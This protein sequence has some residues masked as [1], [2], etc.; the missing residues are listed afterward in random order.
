MELYVSE[1]ILQGEEVPFYLLWSRAEVAKVG[2]RFE[3]FESISFLYNVQ[4]PERAIAKGWVLKED[5]KANGY[6]GGVLRTKVVDEPFHAARLD[7]TLV[8]ENGE[9]RVLSEKRTLN[10][11]RVRIVEFPDTIEVP[12]ATEAPR[13][14]VELEGSVT[15][16]MR[17]EEVEGSKLELALPQEIQTAMERFDIAFAEGLEKLKTEFPKYAKLIDDLINIPKG[18]SLRQYFDRAV[19]GIE[20]AR[21]DEDFME[22][23]AMAFLGALVGQASV[24][25]TFFLPLVEYLEANAANKAFFRSP[26]LCAKVPAG[27]GD[28]AVQL[29]TRD[30]L[31]N[32]CGPPLA[33]KM[34]FRSGQEALVPIKDIIQVRRL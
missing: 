15:V 29:E 2:L 4:D 12:L 33:I 10:T 16:F 21:H 19:T 6:L 26:F 23:M 17:V 1:D 25:D 32:L 11:T 8:L 5:L 34:S 14:Q 31:D 30:L 18:M 3:G 27:G 13:V 24:K 9:S 22:A 20:S 7:A 28:L